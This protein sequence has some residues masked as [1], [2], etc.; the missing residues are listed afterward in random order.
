MSKAEQQAEELRA[1]LER[2]SH[3][4]YN[5]GQPEISDEEYDRL[6]RELQDLEAA[7]PELQR[8]DSPTRRVGAPLPK[9]SS[10]G[11]AEHLLPMLS[12]ESLT[13]DEEVREFEQRARRMLELEGD[14]DADICWALEPKFDGVSANLLYQDGILVRGLSRGDGAQGEDITQNL[15]TIRNLPLH[16]HRTG[17]TDHPPKLIEVRGEVMLSRRA[18]KKLQTEAE[19]TGDT[20]F[21]N[22]RNTVAG[23]LKLLDPRT[24]ATRGLEFIFWGIGQSE[25]LQV[26]SHEE[27]RDRILAYGFKV[28]SQFAVVKTVDEIIAFHDDLERRREEIDY[29]MDGIVAKVDDFELQR[30]MGRTA[31]N[32]RWIL[33]H[34]FA[35]QRATTRVESIV[36]QVGRTGTITPVANLEA[37]ELAGVTVRRATLHNWDLLK[38]RDVRAGD[39]VEIERAGDVIP[40]VISV[41]LSKRDKK[42]K[43]AKPPASCPTCVGDLEK[44]GAFLYCVNL[45]CPDQLKG[46]IVHLASRRALEIV[47]LGP[48]YVDQLMEAGLIEHLED[49]FTLADKREKILDLERWAERSYENLVSEIEKAKQP[50]LARFLYGLGIRHVGEQTAKDLSEALGSLEAI[51]GAGPEQLIEVEGIGE[52]VARSIRS[53]FDR[54]QTDRFLDRIHAAGMR[55]KSASSSSKAGPLLGRTFCFTGGMNNMSRDEAKLLVEGLG[56]KT[57]NSITKKVTDVI[58]GTK[59]GSKLDKAKKLELQILSEEEF[60]ELVREHR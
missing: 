16:L 47:R 34:K 36:A 5:E 52:E 13:S 26:S 20:Q 40:A 1:K 37:V 57:S 17:K 15:K 54:K 19:T 25:G 43:P 21:R 39:Q 58:A 7:H 32:P 14:T 44:E 9:G 10:F 51:R 56:A 2:A 45:E 59:A 3:L 30:R 6:F 38:E 48:K 23:S 49:V 24:V 41:D 4:Y 18:F 11:K 42:S 31:R 50:E 55:V 46:H 27:L 28:S 22:P 33:A 35:P 12:I 60:L 53:F 8:E 29:D